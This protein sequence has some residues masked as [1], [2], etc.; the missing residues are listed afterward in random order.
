MMMWGGE[1]PGSGNKYNQ[2]TLK[3]VL[4]SKC[5]LGLFDHE[6]LEKPNSGNTRSFRE[7][8]EGGKVL[9]SRAARALEESLGRFH[10]FEPT[11]TG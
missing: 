1:Q 5:L 8:E 2:Y 11:W 7:M 9:A 3:V 6:F 4:R 10:K